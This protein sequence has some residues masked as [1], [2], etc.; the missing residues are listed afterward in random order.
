M[1]EADQEKS[2]RANQGGREQA[3]IDP[4][5]AFSP[6]PPPP[7]PARDPAPTYYP[8]PMHGP[9]QPKR[10]G[11]LGRMVGG[12][13]ASILILSVVLNVYLLL[14]FNALTAG[15]SEATYHEGSGDQRIVILPVI[16]GIDR[17]T[18]TFVR[19]ALQHLDKNP[20]AAI[21]LRVESEGGTVSAA[22]AIWHQI[23]RYKAQHPG[24]PIVASFGTV[25]ASGGYYIAA[26]AAHIVCE[27]TCITGSIGVMAQI[28]TMGK[29]MD[30]KLGVDWVTLEADGSPQKTVGNNLFRPWGPADIAS[31][32]PFLNSAYERF[33]SV[34]RQGRPNL[35]PEQLAEATTG[36]AFTAERALALGL[37]DEIGFLDAAIAEAVKL[38]GLPAD[39]NPPVKTI[40]R[41]KPFG[42]GSVLGH[43]QSAAGQLA[44][45]AAMSPEQVRTFLSEL[46]APRLA[47]VLH[48]R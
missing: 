45:L 43:R 7:P 14:M 16:G 46:T 21:V 33:V 39:A 23:E 31:W 27:T 11:V 10:G 24:V 30:E 25:A 20:P 48:W 12:L 19:D 37:V 9:P 32:K 18:A 40:R 6:P 42:L 47:Y 36:E 5:G 44:D 34:V 8:M 1:S 35:T 13:V 4:R 17:D 15:P 41:P 3:P 38:A 2:A 26:T 29:L 28:P 22:D